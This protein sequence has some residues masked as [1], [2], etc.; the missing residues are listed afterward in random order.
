MRSLISIKISEIPGVEIIKCTTKDSVFKALEFFRKSGIGSVVIT[1][2]EQ[3]LAGIFTDRDFIMKIAGRNLNLEKEIL[4][5]YMTPD[6]VCIK[7]DDSVAFALGKMS[8][9]NFRHI[10]VIDND[11]KPYTIISQRDILSLID[12]LLKREDTE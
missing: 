2:E 12:L 3:K 10:I 7:I 9:G 8:Q 1:D 11:G 6:P 4:G 5:D